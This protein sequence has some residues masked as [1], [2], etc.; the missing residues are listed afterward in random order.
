MSKVPKMLEM[1]GFIPS[2][3]HAVPPDVP[4]ENYKFCIKLLRE[5]CEGRT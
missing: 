3:D 2:V 4:F 5:V 1:G